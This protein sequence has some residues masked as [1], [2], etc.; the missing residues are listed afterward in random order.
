MLPIQ[1]YVELEE[2]LVEL[3]IP[4]HGGEGVLLVA[5]LLQLLPAKD[6]LTPL[7]SHAGK[8]ILSC[9]AQHRLF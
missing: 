9:S 8:P 1:F 6:I 7:P 5:M 3:P 4:L 2:L